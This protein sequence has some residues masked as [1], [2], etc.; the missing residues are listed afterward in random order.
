MSIL[1]T[2]DS[3]GIK[4]LTRFFSFI[5]LG[6]DRTVIRYNNIP[7]STLLYLMTGCLASGLIRLVI[8]FNLQHII[9]RLL[10]LPQ[11]A[12]VSPGRPKSV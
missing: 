3:T 11:T 9:T 5:C 4:I 6:T 8:S 7:S 2:H 12:N 1:H 10:G